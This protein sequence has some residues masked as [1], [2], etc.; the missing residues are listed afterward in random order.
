M[1]DI[2]RIFEGGDWDQG[3]VVSTSSLVITNCLLQGSSCVIYC[4]SILHGYIG[5]F[6]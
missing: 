4:L 5:K 3:H 1:E 6:I 2:S